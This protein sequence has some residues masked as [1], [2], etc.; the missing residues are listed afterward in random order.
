MDTLL[1]RYRN[2]TVL[3]LVLFAQLILFAYQVKTNQDVRLIRVWAVSAITPVARLVET[4]RAR[5]TRFFENYLALVGVREE[6]RRLTTELGRLKMENRFLKTEL[7]TA[8]RAQALTAFQSR[9]PSKTAAA[10]IIA[11]G[12]GPNSKVVFVDR[13]AA[14]GVQKGMAVIT[15]DGIV[16]RVMAAYP[17][18]AQVLLIT[19]PNFAAGVVSQK[20]RVQGTL[21]GAGKSYCLIDYIRIEE[22]VEPGE[23]FFTS[24][25]DRVFPR[26]LPVGQVKSLGVG[27]TFRE[28]QVQP[29][30][31]AT[32]LEEVL[33]VL[34]GVHQPIPEPQTGPPGIFML[35]APP[36]D[37]PGAETTAR[38]G[39]TFIMTT[40]ADRM[41][42]QYKRIGEAQGHTYGE[43]GA[44]DFNIKP[45]EPAAT[46]EPRGP[47][48]G[49]TTPAP[50]KPP[51]AGAPGAKTAR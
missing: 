13:G 25:D 27:K 8:D 21:K 42:E 32:G 29:S 3:I 45:P 23:W 28:I 16:G 1:G 26:G 41:R 43:G 14:S 5:V 47:E 40:E 50:A 4:G 51:L 20:H 48:T 46:A 9:Y 12:A 34:E 15:P 24:G 36:A 10:R 33:I 6:N 18:T 7:G 35:P 49:A 31:I 39:S 37:Q 11:T 19:D 22:R 38:E 44:P 2:V 30:G 17:G